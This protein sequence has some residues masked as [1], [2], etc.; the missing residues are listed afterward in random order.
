VISSAC[1]AATRKSS[2][3]AE[4]G[5]KAVNIGFLLERIAPSMAGFAFDVYRA[6]GRP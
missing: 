3:A 6:G 4:K 5:A 2:V 1:E